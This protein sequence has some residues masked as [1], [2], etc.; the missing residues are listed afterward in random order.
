MLEDTRVDCLEQV[1]AQSF[2]NELAFDFFSPIIRFPRATKSPFNVP[3]HCSTLNLTLETSLLK[4]FSARE[5]GRPTDALYEIPLFR[6]PLQ[7]GVE[8][9]FE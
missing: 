7:N 4:N 1:V 8:F 9:D 2:Y 5:S 6:R 3:K